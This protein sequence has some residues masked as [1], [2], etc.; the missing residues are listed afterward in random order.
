M[1]SPNLS[2]TVA[3]VIPTIL[4]RPA[5]LQRAIVSVLAQTY[6]VLE[7]VVVVDDPDA[8]LPC[9]D[10]PQV[11]VVR[12]TG[13]RGPAAARNT[14]IRAATAD[15]IGLLDDD[16]H[17]L[18]HKVAAQVDRYVHGR[19]E[20]VVM[21]RAWAQ[22]PTSSWLVPDAPHDP[23]RPFVDY[24]FNDPGF[25]RAEDHTIPTSTIFTSRALLTD[26]PFVESLPQW[27]DYEWLLRVTDLGHA[28]RWVGE[29]LAIM[30][31]TR[32]TG[33]SQSQRAD[34]DDD[35]RWAD[36]YLAD[37]SLRAWHNHRLTYAAPG[38]ARRGRRRET[39]S[40]IRDAVGARQSPALIAKAVMTTTIPPRWSAALRQLLR[41]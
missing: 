28:V 23:V 13:R 30:D 27:E 38:L 31:Q 7:I 40:L 6:P 24:L 37:R 35:L 32:A 16:D 19:Q 39:A 41:R 22:G 36:T 11:R 17:W 25:A 12:N 29:P 18:P 8:P 26:E 9:F 10:E 20:A 21:A 34:P 3:A 33:L 14:G 15:L 4:K 1:T 5:E 2:P